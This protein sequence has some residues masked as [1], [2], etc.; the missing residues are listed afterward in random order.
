MTDRNSKKTNLF[1]LLE[2][3]TDYSTASLIHTYKTK[4]IKLQIV[5]FF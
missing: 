4:V 1:V 5:L 2:R 3:I